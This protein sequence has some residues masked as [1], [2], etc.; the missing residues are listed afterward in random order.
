MKSFLIIG[1]LLFAANAFAQFRDTGIEPK[2]VKEG[3]VS[4]NS[5]ALFG[6]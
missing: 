5:N 3:I 6:F 1:F 2:S 4:E